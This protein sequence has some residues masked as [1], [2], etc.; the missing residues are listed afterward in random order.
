MGYEPKRKG[1]YSYLYPLAMI[2]GALFLFVENGW[3]IAAGGLL[4][5][6]A[7]KDRGR[8]QGQRS[9]MDFIAVA[10]VLLILYLLSSGLLPNIVP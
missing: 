7:L 6:L 9:R 4:L 5:Y 3:M 10:I 1:N 8:G 2:A